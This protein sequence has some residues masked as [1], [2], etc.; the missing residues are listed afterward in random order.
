MDK[1]TQAALAMINYYAGDKKR[2][3]HFIKV[4]GYAKLIGKAEGLSEREQEILETAAY[5]HDIGIH[6]S[7]KKYNSSSGYYQQLEGPPL[8]DKM[9][10]NI[11]FDR[12]LIDRVCYLISRHHK[13]NNIDGADCQILIEADF[14]VN[15]VEEN[16]NNE[17]V[18]DISKKVFK[19]KAGKK[20]LGSLMNIEEVTE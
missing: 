10:T 14:I 17:T 12:E 18:C 15:A 13:Y 1:L 3:E 4:H 20:I 19:T 8:A 6:E 11:G 16:I 2:I 9:L 7:E 5:L